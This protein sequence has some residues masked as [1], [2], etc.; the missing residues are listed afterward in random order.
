MK[1]SSANNFDFE[2]LYEKDTFKEDVVLLAKQLKDISDNAKAC[3]NDGKF[4]KYKEE[5]QKSY[6]GIFNAMIMFNNTFNGT[7]DAYARKMSMFIQKIY[8]L[9]VLL[10]LVEADKNKSLIQEENHNGES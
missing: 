2:K 6:D 1:K 10:A 3:L 4:I 7:S 9:K 8:D 5:L